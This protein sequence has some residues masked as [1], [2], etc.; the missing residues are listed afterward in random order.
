MKL[1]YFKVLVIK[2]YIMHYI[3]S[4]AAAIGGGGVSPPLYFSGE[5]KTDTEIENLYLFD[6]SKLTSILF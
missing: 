4:R 6:L 5:N 2:S 3:T 1:I